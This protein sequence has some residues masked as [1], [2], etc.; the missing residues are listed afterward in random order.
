MP[1]KYEIL[2]R[3][4]ASLGR[5]FSTSFTSA[6][7]KIQRLSQRTSELN[8]EAAKIDGLIKLREQTKALYAEY[9]RQKQAVDG[10]KKALSESKEPSKIMLKTLA[11]EEKKLA[12]VRASFERSKESV[13]NSNIALSVYGRTVSELVAKQKQMTK[14]SEESAR[15]LKSL[16]AYR[17]KLTNLSERQRNIEEAAVR[18]AVAVSTI[19]RDAVRFFSS[20]VQSAMQMQD[21]MADIAKVVNFDDPK[22]LQNMQRALEQMSMTIPMSA[23]GLAQIAAAAGQAGIKANE[24][25]S[26]TEQAA[27]MG[28]AF[29][30]S[31][32]QAGEMM[33]KWRSGMNLTQ[34]QVLDLANATNALS[35]SNAAQAKQIGEVLKRYGALGKVAGLSEKQ[36]AAL[37]ATAIGAGAEA[38]V[39]ATGINSFMRA[40][41]KGGGMTKLQA[42]AFMNVGYDPKQLQRDVQANAPQ[43]ILSVLESIKVKVPKELQ[44]QYLTAMFGEEGARALGPMLSNIELLRQN[45]ALVADPANYAGSMISEFESRIKTTSS[46]L[47]IAKNAISYVSSAMGSPLL[48][49]VR[50]AAIGFAKCGKAAGDWMNENQELVGTISKVVITGAAMVMG[51]HAIRAA[52][53]FAYTPLLTLQRMFVFTKGAILSSNV[54]MK[55]WTLTCA[56]SSKAVPVLTAGVKG[57]GVAMKF[58]ATN[59]IGIA[60][61]AIAALTTAGIYLY[62][63]W[64]TVKD[65]MSG[66]WIYIADKAKAPFNFVIALVNQMIK[67]INSLASFKLPE[68]LPL[69]G[70]KSLGV[71]IPEIPQLAN[72][73]IATK[74]T[75]AMVGE[76]REPEA[77]MPLSQLPNLMPSS[78]SNTSISVNFSPT[79][80]IS[81][82]SGDVYGQVK[83]GL[84]EGRKD[85]ERE[86]EQILMKHRRLAF[87]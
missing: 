23:A 62:N 44:S 65:K 64:D 57:L 59:P 22:G 46:S 71:N 58:A 40:L 42:N 83:Q 86:I 81:G 52:I 41:T 7:E 1:N 45:F 69:V 70:G 24:L 18:S 15:S 8:S 5:K 3:L 43:A 25:V 50:E 76:G 61:S 77:I 38:E 28:V 35:N 72:G 63:N 75:L 84:S 34:D 4:E 6:D 36:T 51:F 49:P 31:A 30:I 87:S 14:S 17:T 13:K 60:I 78:G 73:G 32:E 2:F 79:I 9:S 12:K 19:G 48:G 74:S 11:Q 55:A 27:K 37:A 29:D 68:G 10:L 20:P 53:L 67:G 82:Q 66:I 54:A 56:A 80:N 39:A 26:F 16:V 33:A 47:E 21:A 85:L